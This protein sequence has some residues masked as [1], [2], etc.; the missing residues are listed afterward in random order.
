M[1]EER[2]ISF[3]F[4]MYQGRFFILNI[5]IFVCL[6]LTSVIELET[7]KH[8]L[9]TYLTSRLRGK[10]T[11]E[12]TVLHLP[13]KRGD[14]LSRKQMQEVASHIEIN[15]EMSDTMQQATSHIPV[16]IRKSNYVPY[17]Q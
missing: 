11:V 6:S 2:E 14:G 15:G 9:S 8:N 3:K 10:L 12:R 4:M 5:S 7:Q 13:L 17:G 1:S 16:Y